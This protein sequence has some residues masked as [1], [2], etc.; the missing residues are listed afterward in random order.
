MK[1]M[2]TYM[3]T[4]LG[5]GAF[6][7]VLA[8]ISVQE[9]SVKMIVSILVMSALI[10]LTAMIYE[11]EQLKEIY[12]GLVHMVLVCGLVAGM[13]AFNGLF[14]WLAIIMTAVIYILVFST[15]RYAMK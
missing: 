10:G 3:A 11:Q 13:L 5:I 8:L 2:V 7:Y 6:S 12:R 4:G 15:G 9:V 14:N 1:K